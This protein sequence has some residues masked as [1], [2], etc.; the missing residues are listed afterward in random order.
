MQKGIF[1][2]NQSQVQATLPS[3]PTDVSKQITGMKRILS[4]IFPILMA[5]CM[6]LYC[7]GCD[8]LMSDQS[9]INTVKNGK[10]NSYPDKTVGKAFDGF[11]GNPVWTE[12]VSEGGEQVVQVKGSCT[13]LDEPITA[14]VQFIL[15]DDDTF[16]LYTITFNDIPQNKLMQYGF[17][18]AVYNN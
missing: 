16:S 8:A 10:L 4:I 13:Y 14:T 3:T 11:L 12:F 6:M 15:D 1:I 2:M 9:I 18:S 17:L 7:T 5:A